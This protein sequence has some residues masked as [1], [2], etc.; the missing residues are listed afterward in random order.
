MELSRIILLVLEDE[1]SKIRLSE[2]FRQIIEY[3]AFQR[4][5]T[6][7]SNTQINHTIDVLIHD[8]YIIKSSS[9]GTDFYQLSSKG[10]NRLKA[11][12]SPE[13]LVSHMSDNLTKVLTLIAT[14]LSIVA[15]Y[16]SI[17]GSM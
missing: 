8:G 7:P 3:P 4:M 12:Y 9:G 2:F 13:K 1:K 11:W 15:T 17:K 6:P 14:I 10:Y 16:F 5:I